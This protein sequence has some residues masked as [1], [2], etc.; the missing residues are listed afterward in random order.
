MPKYAFSNRLKTSWPVWPL[1][2]SATLLTHSLSCAAQ[3]TQ[4]TQSTL[5]SSDT[6]KIAP[7]TQ[8]AANIETNDAPNNQL[9]SALKRTSGGS[10]D[11]VS[12]VSQMTEHSPKLAAAKAEVH[13]KQLQ[14]DAAKWL[15]GPNVILSAS[16]NKYNLSYDVDLTEAK[17]LAIQSGSSI[18]I[19]GMPNLGA[20]LPHLI[21]NDLTLNAKGQTTSKNALLFWP[22]FTGGKIHAAKGLLAARADE[23]QAD[24]IMVE[25]ELY[26]TLVQRY[27]GA[28]L[29]HVAL[30]LRK[31]AVN[32]ISAHDHTAERM[33]QEGL[34][35]NAERLRAKVSLEDAKRQQ[36]KAANDAELANIA[37]QR[38]LQSSETV[39]PSTPIFVLSRPLQALDH[40]QNLA[41]HNHPGLAKVSAKKTQA[42]RLLDVEKGRY[43]PSVSVYGAHELSTH[44][45]S[46]VAGVSASWTLW[47][48]LD[49]QRMAQSAEQQVMQANYSDAQVREDILLL[50][51]KNWRATEN[52][53][54]AYLALNANIDLAKELVRL[55]RSSVREGLATVPDLMTAETQYFQALTEQAK[56][57][58]DYVQALVQLLDSCGTPDAFTDYAARADVRLRAD[59]LNKAAPLVTNKAAAKT[60]KPVS[61]AKRTLA[62]P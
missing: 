28:Q 42:E 23:A 34:I 54:T 9:S 16:V 57:G 45:P 59:T 13:S 43:L 12:A 37:L 11:F 21:P 35:S 30:D 5:E 36:E 10:L 1:C 17:Q 25:D 8:T 3:T 58:N 61:K 14:S 2:L 24:A 55:Q 18:V 60:A 38:L 46:W 52:A 32:T 53:R 7:I 6:A 44:N 27:F 19:P 4:I 22:V 29:A 48:G 26:V 15:G 62:Q 33:L 49:R 20:M 40:F 31:A 47:S 39:Q 51:E 56:A 41:L 50:V